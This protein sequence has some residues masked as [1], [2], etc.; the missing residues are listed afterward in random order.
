MK[1]DWS[2][3]NLVTMIRQT[4]MYYVDLYQFC[5]NPEKA[6]LEIIAQRSLSPPMPSLFD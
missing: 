3:S 6:W 2:F 5:E 4:L 1:R